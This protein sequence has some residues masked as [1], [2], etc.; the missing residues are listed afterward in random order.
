MGTARFSS[1][2]CRFSSSSF[3]NN[4]NN[5]T[6]ATTITNN[7]NNNRSNNYR[8]QRELYEAA[9]I[10]QH[11]YRQYKARISTQRQNEA[12][13]NAAILIQSYYRRYKQFCYFKRL[14][15]A[16]VFIQKHFRMHKAVMRGDSN[17]CLS[18]NV[19]DIKHV[20]Y[21]DA[22]FNTPTQLTMKEHQAALTIQHA[23]RQK[24]REKGFW[25]LADI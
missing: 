22:T 15:K 11:A 25:T 23:F 2:V 5:A 17:H 19:D 21:D 13:R 9:K 8:E 24:G 10:I 16:A 4:T 1:I 7:N 14:H 3:S 18:V 6:A 20:Q 12:E